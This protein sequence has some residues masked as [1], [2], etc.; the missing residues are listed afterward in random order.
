[1]AKVLT[2]LVFKNST[3]I[4]D[5]E[6]DFPSSP[7]F[8]QFCFK[9]G[10]LY[11][12]A[13]IDA[14]ETWYPLTNRNQY[15]VH[16][17][18]LSATSWVV[19]HNL[20][21]ED[22]IFMVYDENDTQIVPSSVTFDSNDQITLSF[23]E[24]TKGKCVVFGASESFTP[25]VHTSQVTVGSDITISGTS[26]V[27]SG[28]D[29]VALLDQTQSDL[30]AMFSWSESQG[31]ITFKGDLIPENDNSL[32]IG[33]ATKKIKDVYISAETLHVGDNATFE[34][35]S[36]AIDAGPSPTS[37]GDTPTVQASSLILKPFTYNPG[38]GNVN[39]EPVL[40]FQNL[41]GQQYGISFNLVDNEFQL[42]SP[43]GVGTG[44]LKCQEMTVNNKITADTIETT[45]TAQ[46]KFDQGLRVDGDVNLG[47]DQNNTIA[48]KGVVDLQTP[49][50]F[51]ES[52]TLG[53]GNDDIAVN[54]GGSNDF[55]V[56]AQNVDISSA[57]KITASEMET[58]GNMTV[59]GDLFVNG[60]QT[61][62]DTTT[63]EVTD[64]VIGVNNG[65]AGA[66][67]TA[68]FAGIR[69]D[70]GSLPDARLIY[71]ETTDKWQMGI[72]GSMS[73]I[74]VSNHDHD[75]DYLRTDADSEP[76]QDN[77]HD[78]G[79]G[80][81]RFQ[82]IHG[83]TIHGE[84]NGNA[85]TA[86]AL[87]TSRTIN[88]TGDA[89]GSA[90]FD[91]TGDANITLTVADDSH[92]HDGRYFTESE[93]DSR[94]LRRNANST[95]DVDISYDLGDAT[96]RW[97]NVYAQAFK[98]NADSASKWQN[99][100]TITL[101]GDV[102]GS[103]AIDGSGNAS[104]TVTVA[105][106]SHSHN[107]DYYTKAECNTNFANVSGDTMTGALQFGDSVKAQFGSGQDLD[108]Y[109]DGTN[110]LLNC[111]TGDFRVLHNG[112]ISFRSIPNGASYMYH[113]NTWR[114]A[115]SAAGVTINGVMSGQASS[116]LYA[117]L[118]ENLTCSEDYVYPG[119]VMKACETGE[120]DAEEC[121]TEYARNVLGVV[122]E[123][124]AYLMNAEEKGVPV[125]YTG[126]VRVRI[127]GPVGKGQPI[128]SAGEG[129]ARG[130]R[131]DSE[132]LYS[133]G[134]TLEEHA[135]NEEQLV[136]CIIK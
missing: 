122:S 95:P 43:S 121:G 111:K 86:T 40:K 133:F 56:S 58:S 87:E 10:I 104:C 115:T 25:A 82:N 2:N 91:G 84:L 99:S 130:I 50:T 49:I 105:D 114:I 89:S 83:T 19:G 98:G 28:V 23:T 92:N 120:F 37:L 53:D 66:G 39:V 126:K 45:G 129:V 11:I 88:I 128:V 119:T 72:E 93:Q 16:T 102:S 24:S 26:I 17:Q 110:G 74:S 4:L 132:L 31:E 117:D 68:G 36:L 73:D 80:D 29:I 61:V 78:L 44:S 35:T 75:A 64:N 71:N 134:I 101:S 7:E 63:L 32:S 127:V 47:Y 3:P 41:G 85:A 60:T 21:T 123:N 1:M 90:A 42:D 112:E 125:A 96:H 67:I 8:G 34:G 22:I 33:S 113:D 109:H 27:V 5:E 18:A 38:A 97:N 6:A 9:G 30:N 100:R 54:C 59:G 15:A 76:N 70:R 65:E 81:A 116:A 57:G 46:I 136:W 48:I 12:Y 131:K 79:A 20:Q 103:F 118:A 108:V 77:V 14:T 107:T 135:G 52:A 106:D 124:P 94:F 55:T 69:V 51:S 13:T 62:V